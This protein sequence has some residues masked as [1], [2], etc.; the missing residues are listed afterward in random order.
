MA[1]R[2][3][4][5]TPRLRAPCVCIGT[6]YSGVTYAPERPPSTKKVEAVT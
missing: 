2:T 1:S 4:L 6:S 5:E 3:L